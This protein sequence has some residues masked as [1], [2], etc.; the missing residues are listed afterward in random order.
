MTLCL[1]V[2]LLHSN[3]QGPESCTE[4]MK[5]FCLKVF[6][7][8]CEFGTW[9][10]LTPWLSSTNCVAHMQANPRFG[11]ESLCLISLISIPTFKVRSSS[12]RIGVLF[13]SLSNAC[14]IWRRLLKGVFFGGIRK[15]EHVAQ[16][17]L[18]SFSCSIAGEVHLHP[19]ANG[20]MLALWTGGVPK[21]SAS[22]IAVFLMNPRRTRRFICKSGGRHKNGFRNTSEA[23]ERDAV[24]A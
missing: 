2:G 21:R 7:G 13:L 11:A 1:G 16:A 18:V 3:I 14:S 15:R 12:I 5:A 4:R 22:V 8:R 10:T 19:A 20:L 17:V 23:T 9:M 24:R 6:R